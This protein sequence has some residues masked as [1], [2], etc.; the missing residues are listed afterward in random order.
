MPKTSSAQAPV[1][2]EQILAIT[3]GSW[4]SR[5]LAV[6]AEL[7]LADLLAEHPLQ[8]DELAV[9]TRT[10]L[11]VCSVCYVHLKAWEYSHKYP[12]RYSLIL[13]P[14]NACARMFRIR[15]RPLF[16]LN[17]LLAGACTKRGQAWVEAFVQAT[18]PSIKSMGMTSGNSVN[19]TRK[20]GKSSTKR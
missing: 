3:S 10:T 19:S 17:F 2:H 14:A 13:P 7:E 20:P 8:V 12:L 4:Q 9:R 11:R 16:A 5:A 15:C 1:P 18:K 6:A